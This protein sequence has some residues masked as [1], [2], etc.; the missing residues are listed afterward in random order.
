MESDPADSLQ[1]ALAESRTDVRQ[2][3]RN[4]ALKA[5]GGVAQTVRERLLTPASSAA[6]GMSVRASLRLAFAA[7]VAGALVIGVFSL[8]QMGRLNTSTQIIYEQEYTAGQAAEQVRS[9]I[10]RASRAQ[11]QLLTSSTAA[12]RDT[13]AKDIEGSLAE[14]G[15]KIEIIQG[16]SSTEESKETAK[17]LV[18]SIAKWSKRLRE[19]VKL[20]KEQPLSFMELSPDVASEDAGLVNETR[21]VEKFVDAMVAQR[22]QSAQATMTQAAEIYKTSLI[23]VVGIVLLLIA[24]SIGVGSWVIARLT[25]QLGGEP[26]YAKSI[27]SRIADGDLTMEIQLASNDT[28]SLLYS[29]HEMQTRLAET[30][31]EIAESSAQVANA[32]REISMGNL[33]LSNRTE[34][35]AANLQ[36]A[37]ASLEHLSGAVHQSANA[38]SQANTLAGSAYAVA[39]SGG[40]SVA[41]VVQTMHLIDG[42]SKKIV[43]IISVI[44]GIAFQTNILAL[45]AAVEAARAGEQGRGFA[46]VASEVRSLAGRSAAAAKEVKDLIGASVANVE[47]GTKLVDQAGQTMQDIV[48]SVQRVTGMIEE[49]SATSSEQSADMQQVSSAVA[50]LEQMTQQNAA[51]VEQ[52]AAA[53]ASMSEQAAVLGELVGKFALPE[54]MG[55]TL[56]LARLP[57]R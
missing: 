54:D 43:D 29:L 8:F 12:E 1:P 18:E 32:S 26:A 56:A 52:S 48:T 37:S 51:L 9:N 40:K 42:S 30:M 22:G 50:E 28:H 17:Q 2:L 16:L 19:Y 20:V 41:Q 34:Q 55:A 47:V 27:A 57:R 11:T 23:W 10:L 5:L 24:A 7:V 45:N 3:S 44:D 6:D 15:K 25:R 53:A 36:R 33:D 14:V 35:T 4:P 39:E 13:L 31:G 49:I 21:K 38:A 46:V